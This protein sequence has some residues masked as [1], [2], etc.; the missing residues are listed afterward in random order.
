MCD[1]PLAPSPLFSPLLA[2]FPPFSP[3]PFPPLSFLSLPFPSLQASLGDNPKLVEFSSL[4]SLP[5]ASSQV[6][7]TEKNREEQRREEARRERGKREREREREIRD[8][9][10]CI[11]LCRIPMPQHKQFKLL[12]SLPYIL[13]PPGAS[14]QHRIWTTL[15]I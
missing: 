12:C 5:G 8:D 11:C 7:S 4:S 9:S 10:R 6:S 14:S 15:L 1:L 3:L 2:P 13:L